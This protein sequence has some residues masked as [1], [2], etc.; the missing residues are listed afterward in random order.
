MSGCPLG[1]CWRCWICGFPPSIRHW[2]GERCATLGHPCLPCPK[3]GHRLPPPPVPCEGLP[4]GGTPQTRVR[5]RGQQVSPDLN[6]GFACLSGRGEIAPGMKISFRGWEREDYG[7]PS[8]S[9][10]NIV[11]NN[12][13]DND[14]QVPQWRCFAWLPEHLACVLLHHG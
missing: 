8:A 10:F 7:L 6:M 12:E 11:N 5:H 1:S 4:A 13:K 14:L 9:I 3:Q 2:A